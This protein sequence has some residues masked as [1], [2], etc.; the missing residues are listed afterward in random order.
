MR[1]SKKC[2]RTKV[3]FCRSL[4]SSNLN[5]MKNDFIQLESKHWISIIYH[6]LQL[7]KSSICQRWW[8]C[9]QSTKRL[10][11]FSA[12]ISYNWKSGKPNMTNTECRTSQ[13]CSAELVINSSTLIWASCTVDTT[14]RK[15][16]SWKL[17]MK[18]ICYSWIYQLKQLKLWSWWKGTR[19]T[20]N[21][22]S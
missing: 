10:T 6:S 21:L 4:T 7:L 12:I 22:G 14:P 11:S 3:N 5:L 16:R 17:K 15:L 20:N 2:W 13:V 19:T 1:K 18:S 8:I 9:F